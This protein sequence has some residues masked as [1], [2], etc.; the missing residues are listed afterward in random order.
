MNDTQ[1]V[2]PRQ[3]SSSNITSAVVWDAP[4]P[5]AKQEHEDVLLDEGSSSGSVQQHALCPGSDSCHPESH[6][7]SPLSSNSHQGTSRM[8]ASCDPYKCDQSRTPHVAL[9]RQL[10]FDTSSAP[11]S[12]ENTSLSGSSRYLN[13]LQGIPLTTASTPQADSPHLGG[14]TTKGTGYPLAYQTYFSD[15]APLT[16]TR[17]QQPSVPETSSA[18]S[19]NDASRRRVKSDK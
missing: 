3:P 5:S 1:D 8:T 13:A 19:C 7:L 14:A 16:A 9:L 12:F 10:L 17:A 2:M 6:V 15:L 18:R 4:G 11:I